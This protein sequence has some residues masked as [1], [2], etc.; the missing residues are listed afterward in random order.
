MKSCAQILP[1]LR[2][3]ESLDGVLRA[4]YASERRS[5]NRVR[6]RSLISY[7]R[8]LHPP[9][10]LIPFG[11][12]CR[13]PLAISREIPRLV[14]RY[15][16]LR[17]VYPLKAQLLVEARVFVRDRSLGALDFGGYV[18]GCA[19]A[20]PRRTLLVVLILVALPTVRFLAAAVLP[21]TARPQAAAFLTLA[22]R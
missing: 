1:G 13:A 22:G 4:A 5:C 9:P 6:I 17:D 18:S 3:N 8:S 2:V 14:S 20:A 21:L 11:R 19:V 12:L 15:L 7:C 16:I 10:L